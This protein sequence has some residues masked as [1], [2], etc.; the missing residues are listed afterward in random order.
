MSRLE[1]EQAR[2]FFLREQKEKHKLDPQYKEKRPA[3]SIRLGARR[4]R[5][6]QRIAEQIRQRD[7]YRVELSPQVKSQLVAIRDSAEDTLLHIKR[8]RHEKWNNYYTRHTANDFNYR[9]SIAQSRLEQV[10]AISRLEGVR[11]G[12]L[13]RRVSVLIEELHGQGNDYLIESIGFDNE[14]RS[15]PRYVDALRS[16]EASLPRPN[17]NG[18]RP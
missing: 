15:I 16:L 3:H 1:V 13:D 4:F 12:I 9:P 10:W 8:E 18:L 14:R 6:E 5:T 7:S 11:D 2:Q 17:I